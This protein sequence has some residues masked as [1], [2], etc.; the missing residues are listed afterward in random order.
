MLNIPN[1]LV[2]WI[3]VV[4][5]ICT[6][7]ASITAII[8]LMIWRKQQR[9]APKFN[10]VMEL[11]DRHELL[12]LEYYNIF[13]WLYGISK[14]AAESADKDR[15]YKTKVDE[16]IKS[17][18][19]ELKH[20]EKLAICEKDYQLQYARL[21]RLIDLEHFEL[22]DYKA[23]SE[24]YKNSVSL[25]KDSDFSDENDIRAVEEMFSHNFRAFKNDALKQFKLIREMI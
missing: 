8:T 21:S 11:E 5:G 10:A 12:M 3:S 22:L 15:S 2:V 4:S 6:I 19:K 1:D 23:L 13:T 18:F 9:Y 16:K 14:L 25:I 17:D 7:M 20:A 24:F